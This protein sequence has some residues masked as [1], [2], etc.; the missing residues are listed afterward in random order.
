MIGK[1]IN[2]TIRHN[3]CPKTV[4]YLSKRTVLKVVCYLNFYA[5]K[6]GRN[7]QVHCHIF[8]GD[9]QGE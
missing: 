3:I 8:I 2:T 7:L 5:E 9:N 1:C 4:L 6:H